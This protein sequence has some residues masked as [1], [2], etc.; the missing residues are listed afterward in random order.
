VLATTRSV[1]I[2]AKDIMVNQ[3]SVEPI[4]RERRRTTMESQAQEL[5]IAKIVL[6]FL[7]L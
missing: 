6:T 3:F 5:M 4:I 7:D 2:S 1:E